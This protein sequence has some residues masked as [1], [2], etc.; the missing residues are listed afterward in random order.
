[1][2]ALAARLALCYGARMTEHQQTP[3]YKPSRLTAKQRRALV[4]VAMI[5]ALLFLVL[6]ACM[7]KISRQLDR[8]FEEARSAEP[9]RS[10]DEATPAPR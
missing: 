10:S 6:G 5:L 1:M 7:F 8:R 4:I 2:Q 3:Q 9:L